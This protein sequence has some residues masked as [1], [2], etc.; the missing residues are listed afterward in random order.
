MTFTKVPDVELWSNVKIPGPDRS[1]AYFIESTPAKIDATE[2]TDEELEVSILFEN[3]PFIPIHA[4]AR[5]S[6]AEQFR[7][8]QV[9]VRLPAAPS[10][11]KLPF[12][13]PDADSGTEN[14]TC[15]TGHMVATANCFLCFLFVPVDFTNPSDISIAVCCSLDKKLFLRQKPVAINGDRAG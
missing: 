3:N 12:S 7:S 6:G 9:L 4:R 13:F 14:S 2:R 10:S 15:G 11:K 1:I 5:G 8:G